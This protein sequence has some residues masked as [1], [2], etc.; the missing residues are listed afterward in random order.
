MPALAGAPIRWLGGSPVL[1]FNLLLLAGMVTTAFAGFYVARS[2]TGDWLAGIL[3]GSLLAFNAQTLVA[4][5]TPPGAS[6]PVA[7]ARSARLRTARRETPN[8]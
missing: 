2:I 7:S 3:T 5:T 6:R 1:T 4:A 8:P